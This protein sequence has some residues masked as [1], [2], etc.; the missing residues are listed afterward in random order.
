[1]KNFNICVHIPLYLEK[2]KKKQ[3]KNF[4]KVCTSF[5]KLSKKTKIFI[6]CNKKLKSKNKRIKYIFHSFK[7]AHPFKLTWYCRNLME[8]QK[9]DYDIFIYC[10]DDILFTKKNFKYWIENKENC[11]KNDY[12][13]GFLRV[14]V[15]KKNKKLYSTD[16]VETSKFLVDL[17]KK[18]YICLANSN[19][20]FWIYDKNEFNKFITSK[21]WSFEWKWIS[22]SDILLIREMAAVGWHGKNMNGLD[23]DRYLNTIV[24]LINKKLNSNSFIRHLSDNYANAPQ[25][26]F[27]TFKI[28][29]IVDKNLKKFVPPSNIMNFF[30]RFKYIIYH[31]LRINIKRYF[32]KNKLHKDLR[33]GLIFR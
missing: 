11:I 14:E 32:K 3:I 8:Q 17:S 31:T 13:L 2:R 4:K 16:Q 6:H 12:N 19:C 18:K 28:N 29:D 10:E 5:L 1:M 23:M 22:I 15:N 26:F 21:F 20:S 25:G 7:N 27:G 9:E 33:S 30:K 24:P